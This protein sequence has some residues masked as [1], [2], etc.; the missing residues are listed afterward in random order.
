MP[1]VGHAPLGFLHPETARH[2]L[3]FG[4][5]LVA[6]HGLINL[7]TRLVALTD[8]IVQPLPRTRAP[9]LAIH[10]AN[11][12]IANG[13]PFGRSDA[14]IVDDLADALSGGTLPL[15]VDDLSQYGEYGYVARKEGIMVS[16]SAT[17]RALRP[18][19]EMPP[20]Q[21][22]LAVAGKWILGQ[23]DEIDPDKRGW[24]RTAGLYVPDDAGDNNL[25][26]EGHV[27]LVTAQPVRRPTVTLDFQDTAQKHPVHATLTINRHHQTE[28]F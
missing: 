8:M 23:I 15:A 27:D 11:S 22:D 18:N 5:E 4:L 7:S 6:L 1:I 3:D 16:V 28:M 10:V 20:H 14:D 12:F 17:P 9:L 19:R 25:I 26:L 2:A 13:T 24:I 21:E